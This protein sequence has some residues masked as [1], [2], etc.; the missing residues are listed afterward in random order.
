MLTNLVNTILDGKPHYAI[1][2]N[3]SSKKDSDRQYRDALT[4][5]RVLGLSLDIRDPYVLETQPTAKKPSSVTIKLNGGLYLSQITRD[6]F[7]NAVS[8]K[9]NLSLHAGEINNMLSEPSILEKVHTSPKNN[10]ENPVTTMSNLI[11]QNP[12]FF[13]HIE[14]IQSEITRIHRQFLENDLEYSRA[15]SK[16]TEQELSL[17]GSQ[18]SPQSMEQI[19]SVLQT[20]DRS[21]AQFHQHQAETTR[22]HEQYLKNQYETITRLLSVS[23]G[24]SL[25]EPI[26]TEPEPLLLTSTNNPERIIPSVSEMPEI[27]S[28][29]NGHNGH[30]S[31]V[32]VAVKTEKQERTT[33]QVEHIDRD[34]LNKALLKIV[35]E[36]TGYPSEMLELSMDMEADLGID[37]IKRVEILG[38]MQ[39]K[40]PNLPAVD[41]TALSDLRTLGQIVDYMSNSTS[42]MINDVT[43][44][45]SVAGNETITE[46]LSG[47]SIT[48]DEITRTLLNIV[49]EKTGYPSEMLETGMDMEADL[50]IDSIKRVE[51]LGA[52]QEKYPQLPVIDPAALSEMRT[53]EQIIQFMTS[54]APNLL[55]PNQ[56][57][58]QHLSQKPTK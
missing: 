6:A 4:Q 3:G 23:H 40:F 50:G 18:S 19:N 41:P 57:N 21:L 17:A 58:Q 52:M 28:G 49:S 46:K 34:N 30:K 39:E 33:R 24:L 8:K 7:Q 11:T 13:K 44:I 55:I 53:L 38:A 48:L 42:A 56:Y 36:K 14:A 10:V 27:H 35:S 45:P 22:I 31:T 9:N 51:I 5:L 2:L 15:F 43:S 29:G 37:S 12:S 54:S 25:V 1:A 26:P 20:L 32:A 16:L 47:S